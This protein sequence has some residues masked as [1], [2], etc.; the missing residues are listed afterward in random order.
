MIVPTETTSTRLDAVNRSSASTPRIKPPRFAALPVRRATHSILLSGTL[1]TLAMALV[2]WA[3]GH[4]PIPVVLEQPA[5]E[6]KAHDGK[7][8]T[9]EP[10]PPVKSLKAK[11][12]TAP[13]ATPKAANLKT[14]DAPPAPLK[15]DYAGPQEIISLVPHATNRVQ[16]IL[17]PDLAAPPPLKFPL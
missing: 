14:S 15:R 5:E 7:P 6:M 4:L 13:K 2:I 8:I 1:H 9:F 11:S 3:P 10:L 17:R 16:T 12:E